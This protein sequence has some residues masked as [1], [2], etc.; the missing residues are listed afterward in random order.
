MP[1]YWISSWITYGFA[2]SALYYL[3]MLDYRKITAGAGG[4]EGR[5]S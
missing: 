1:K 4:A 3:R 5:I 2:S